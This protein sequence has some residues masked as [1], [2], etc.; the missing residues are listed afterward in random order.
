MKRQ[1]DDILDE[2]QVKRAKFRKI[3]REE[4]AFLDNHANLKKLSFRPG[5]RRL[6]Q[7]AYRSAKSSAL[8]I[9]EQKKRLKRDEFK[10]IFFG[11]QLEDANQ[12][13]DFNY[14]HKE[15]LVKLHLL[16]YSALCANELRW[17]KR[18][19]FSC[20]L[21]CMSDGLVIPPDFYEKYDQ[22]EEVVIDYHIADEQI[23]ILKNFK[24]NGTDLKVIRRSADSN[25]ELW[26]RVRY[27]W[28]FHLDF[29]DISDLYEEIYRSFAD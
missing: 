26:C 8:Q 14:S 24:E 4:N 20:L 10:L 11:V 21:R 3:E 9:L 12:L 22:V 19:N 5:F 27:D 23:D 28:T 13:F 6:C 25:L 17:V 16:N 29:E 7:E 2:L 15:D 1:R 18:V